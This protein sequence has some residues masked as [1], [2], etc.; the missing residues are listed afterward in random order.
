MNK[1]TSK[2]FSKSIADRAVQELLYSPRLPQVVEEFES[3]LQAEQEKRE[4]FYDEVSEQHKA[5]FI[6]GEIIVHSPVKLRHSM[7]SDNLFKLLSTYVQRHDLGYVGHEKLLIALTR[8]DYEP[9]ICYFDSEKAKEFTLDQMKFPAPDLVV[10]VLSPTTEANDRGVKFEDYAVHGV[11]E[12]WIVD[13]ER[14]F[15][16]QYVLSEDGYELIV[17]VKRGVIAGHVIK[18]FEIPVR[19]IFDSHEQFTAL[20]VVLA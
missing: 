19:A 5:E 7:T 12:Y 15:V 11:S 20:Q 18:G 4:R 1:Y 9:D 6:N 17:K 8:N 3:I 13:P 2:R 14:E 10:E 16:E